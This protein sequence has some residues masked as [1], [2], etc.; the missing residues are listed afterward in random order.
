MRDEARAELVDGQLG[1]S[2][3]DR[4]HLGR[5]WTRRSTI[6]RWWTRIRIVR[7]DCGWHRTCFKLERKL[8]LL[9]N[10]ERV[11]E[12]GTYRR[13]PSAISALLALFWRNVSVTFRCSSRPQY[14]R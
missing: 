3:S 4:G 6:E 9:Y 8:I 13:S 2:K 5:Q 1:K 14:L 11:E 7:L 12:C 10:T